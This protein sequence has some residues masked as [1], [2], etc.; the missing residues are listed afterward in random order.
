MAMTGEEAEKL[1]QLL[2]LEPLEEE[3]GL[4]RQ[5]YVSPFRTA[6]DKGGSDRC[7]TAI[8]YM[9]RGEAFSHMHRLTGDE[10]Y[11]FYLG[12]PV[13]LLELFPDGTWSVTILG[14]DL[15]AGQKLQ[16]LVKAGTWQG[17]RLVKGGGGALLATTN[18]PGYTDA[19]YTHGKAEEL[20]E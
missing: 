18:W 9:L 7:G 11:H 6:D 8:Y 20:I 4:V 1:I 15:Q 5:T 19:S 16:H 3:G 17:S 14:R 12:D 2:G 13:E 10:M